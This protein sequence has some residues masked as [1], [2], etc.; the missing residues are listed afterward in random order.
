[1]AWRI[2]GTYVAA[3]NCV[4]VCP[5][6][7][8][9]KPTSPDGE[10]RGVIVFG[11]REGNHDDVDLSGLD[12]ALYNYWPENVGAGRWKLGLV[13]DE[14]ASDEQAQALERIL[15]GQAGGPFEDFAALTEE[16][17]GMER[18][19]VTFSDGDNPSGSVAGKSE[20]AFEPFRGP[21]G[22]PTTVRNA[23]FGFSPEFQIGS[24]SG[25]S[26]AF[27]MSIETVYGETADF[28]FSS[29]AAEEVRPRA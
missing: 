25:R 3:C 19:Q 15:S 26:D 21:D 10:C 11:V 24:A 20:F 28:E 6:P 5:C 18:A 2:A 17:L 4:G 16:Y 14:G 8:D 23:A 12:F 22:S 1:M 9:Q 7:T 27:G 29:E 13:V